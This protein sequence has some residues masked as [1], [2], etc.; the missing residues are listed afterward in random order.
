MLYRQ[1]D[2][3][4]FDEP[5]A[6][7]TPQ[8]IAE[9]MKIMKSLK[10]EGKSIVIITHKLG[11][12]KEVS[13][14][15][16]LES[17]HIQLTDTDVTT[18]NIRQRSQKGLSY[19]PADRH[20]FGLDLNFTLGDNVVLKDYMKQPFSHYGILNPVAIAQMSK[21]LIERFDIRCMNGD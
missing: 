21:S 16:S 9:L 12:V 15:R 17:G 18:L 5:T 10:A 13:D 11:E 1:S 6:V 8:E 4:I 19:I 3:L 20:R 2:I 14:L 7:L